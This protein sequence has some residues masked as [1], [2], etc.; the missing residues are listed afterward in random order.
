MRK[1]MTRT[2]QN[3]KVYSKMVELWVINFV[4]YIFYI[5]QT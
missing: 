2:K 3:V 1:F 4:V 5:F